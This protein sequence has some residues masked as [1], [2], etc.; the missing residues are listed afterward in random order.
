MLHELGGFAVGHFAD[1][2]EAGH[3]LG[4]GVGAG[5]GFLQGARGP[6]FQSHFAEG[7]GVGRVAVQ[8]GA[9]LF[10][11]SDPLGGPLIVQHVGMAL[12]LVEVNGEGVAIEDGH[13]PGIFL[14]AALGQALAAGATVLGA[15][16]LGGAQVGVVLAGEIL[17]PLGGINGLLVEVH[18]LETGLAGLG[19]AA[20]DARI[21]GHHQHRGQGGAGGQE[22]HADQGPGEQRSPLIGHWRDPPA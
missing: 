17:P 19:L 9:G 8:A 11:L 2:L 6:V 7:H 15:V 21:Q 14:D 20:G 13:Q 5:E 10:S 4:L 22:P 3:E 12:A 1:G 18:Q 16:L